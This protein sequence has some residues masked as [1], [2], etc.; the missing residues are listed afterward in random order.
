MEK[1]STLGFLSLRKECSL[2]RGPGPSLAPCVH[3]AYNSAWLSSACSGSSG[4]WSRE[5]TVLFACSGSPGCPAPQVLGPPAQGD[6]GLDHHPR[7]AAAAGA[8]GL[9][10]PQLHGAHRGA[11]AGRLDHLFHGAEVTAPL[12]RL[13]APPASRPAPAPAAACPAERCSASDFCPHGPAR[14]AN[15]KTLPR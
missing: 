7:A 10:A 14:P 6:A 5:G 3:A 12:A 9:R 15:E 8:A 11:A 1:I 13:P 4:G 2:C